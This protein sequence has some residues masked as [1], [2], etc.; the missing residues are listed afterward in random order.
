M[1][2]R[3]ESYATAPSALMAPGR[4]TPAPNADADLLLRMTQRFYTLT[5]ALSIPI[6]SPSF[7][8]GDSWIYSTMSSLALCCAEQ[9]TLQ[10]A[11]PLYRVLQQLQM[12][13]R[14]AIEWGIDWVKLGIQ[15]LHSHTE[16]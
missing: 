5:F 11:G 12:R 16:V 9:S 14:R 8:N 2:A 10:H 15:I 4:Y 6:F 7:N 13:D 1:D 3:Q